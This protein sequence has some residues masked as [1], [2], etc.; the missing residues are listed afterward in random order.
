MVRGLTPQGGFLIKHVLSGRLLDSANGWTTSG[1]GLVIG[2]AV[3]GSTT[4][5]WSFVAVP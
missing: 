5:Q 4:Q 1:T 3:A 2:N